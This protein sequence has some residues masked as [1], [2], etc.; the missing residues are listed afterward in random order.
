LRALANAV[1]SPGATQ[2]DVD[3]FLE[4][5]ARPPDA[6]E[7]PRSR[8]DLLLALLEDP[9]LAERMGSQGQSARAATLEALLAMGYPYALEV[10]P[11][12]LERI[13]RDQ[14]RP[15]PKHALRGL[16]L[17][18]TASALPFLTLVAP[19]LG[20]TP[21]MLGGLSALGTWLRWPGLRSFGN[22]LL[23]LVG[24]VL[25]AVGLSPAV[26][27]EKMP[28]EFF[29]LLLTGILSGSSAFTLRPQKDLLPED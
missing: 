6:E 21:L 25:V 13:R 20:F 19:T 28:A 24:S 22:A 4:A 17:A 26:F 16:W 8:A 18:A 15:F 11:E 23:W 14:P 12:V 7:A 1:R 5:L 2:V 27:A 10:P 9:I 3:D 29:I